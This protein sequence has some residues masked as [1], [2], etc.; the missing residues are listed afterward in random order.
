MF[1]FI[2]RT[3]SL[4]G[5]GIA[6]AVSAPGA[7][8]A[9]A[10]TSLE[11]SFLEDVNAARAAHGLRPVRLDE[12]LERA[13]RE[14]TARMIDDGVFA[15]G[16]WW[17]QLEQLG[18]RGPRLGENL[19]WCAFPASAPRRIVGLWLS[20]PDHRAVLLRAG[21]DR[22]GIGAAIGPFKGFDRAAVVTA[23]FEGT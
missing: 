19:G 13:A 2:A 8:R 14:H 10:L 11:H 6:L 3:T 17:Q 18:A 12:T 23:E 5:V 20:S 16:D 7:G 1:R 22:V 15:H 21:F 9:V 4:V